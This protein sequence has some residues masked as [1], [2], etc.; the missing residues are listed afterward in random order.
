MAKR[1]TILCIA[2]TAILASACQYWPQFMGDA[3]HDGNDTVCQPLWTAAAPSDAGPVVDGGFLF[4]NS[5]GT[6]MAFDANGVTNCSG[7]PKVCQPRWT[8]SVPARWVPTVADGKVYVATGTSPY[9]LEAFDESGLNGC[10]GTPTV[11][12]PLFTAP[13]PGTVDG[14]IAVSGGTAY[15]LTGG[16][17]AALDAGGVTNCSG[18][19][20]VCQPLWTAPSITTSSQEGQTPRDRG[21]PRLRPRQHGHHRGRRRH[22]DCVGSPEVRPRARRSRRARA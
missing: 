12:Q 8:A 6:L 3:A 14:S 5:R 18:P 20:V 15:V 21:R 1:Y 16:E 10:S 13:L 2:I 7:N 17:F 4:I 22:A 9:E 11:C 19:P